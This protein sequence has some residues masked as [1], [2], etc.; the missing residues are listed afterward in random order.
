[1]TRVA[2]S[3]NPTNHLLR[4]WVVVGVALRFAT[5]LGLHVR[6]EDP[7]ASEAKREVL[8]RVWWSLY[9]LERQLSII[10]G[11]PSV[12]VDSCCSVPL[13]VP[14]S[15][16]QI[17]E[18]AN[19]IDASRRS[20]LA[21]NIS[22]IASSH[23]FS[24]DNRLGGDSGRSPPK[25]GVAEPN[26]ASYFRAVVQMCIVTQSILTSLYSAATL[27]RSPGDIQQD[28]VRI[29]ERIDIWA[30]KLP[31]EFNFQNPQNH[32]A[33]SNNVTFRQRTILAFQF[34]NAKILLTRP[35][36]SGLGK[37]EK[38]HVEAA[39]SSSFS[40][41]MAGI[42]VDAA[43]MELDLLPDQP[44]P[45]FVYEFGPWWT[46]VHHLM[47]ALAVFLLALSYSPA[48]Q[49]DNLVLAD[50]CL[51]IIRWLHAMEDLQAERAHQVAIG[52]YEII[53]TRLS[54]PGA[55]MWT[56]S[57]M[58]DSGIA[59]HGAA[60]PALH[61]FHPTITGMQYGPDSPTPAY[62]GMTGDSS[63]FS[64]TSEGLFIPSASGQLYNGTYLHPF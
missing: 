29:G 47:Q 36:L 23:T 9:Y 31:V 42:C 58:P 41:R 38:E 56:S 50:Y 62:S 14:F 1:M 19:L 45:R 7:S 4:A 59:Q 27:I 6:N 21:S 35:C 44:Q 8:V 2:N 54:L 39:V 11:R 17:A 15:E 20:S 22:L 18:N 40:R 61:G 33:M 52:C 12:I 25:I 10:T 34:C 28:I 3:N 26:T 13:P 48:T 53:A 46:L 57:Q 43:K 37:A 24:S 49:Q 64:Y 16:Q 51:K 63:T 32:V 30:Q 60:Q 5:A 55:K